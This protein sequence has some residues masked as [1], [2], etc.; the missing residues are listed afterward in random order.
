M[1]VETDNTKMKLATNNKTFVDI[2]SKSFVS[3]LW[4]YIVFIHGILMYIYGLC[5][6]GLFTI[7]YRIINVTT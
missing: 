7:Y 5:R 4:I 6:R 1:I 2:D 3:G